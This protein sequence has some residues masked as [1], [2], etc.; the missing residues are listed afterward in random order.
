M[1]KNNC[2]LAHKKGMKNNI[3][4][5]TGIAVLG[6]GFT[7]CQGQLSEKPPVHPNP[8]MDQMM[9]MEAQEENTFFADGRSMREP[10]PGTVARGLAKLDTEYYEG[11]DAAGNFVSSNPVDLTQAFLYRGK[12]RYEVFCTPCHGQA[13]EGDGIIMVGNYGYVPAPSFH[14]PRIQQ[15]PDGEIYSAIH[16]GVRTMPSYRTQIRVEDR[17]AIVGYVRALQASFNVNEA[18]L[19]QFGGDV[20]ELQSAYRA[21]Q[22]RQDSIKEARAAQAGDKAENGGG[23]AATIERGQEVSIQNACGACHNTD[24]AAGG[25]GPTWADL[26]GSEAEVVTQD[27]Q[28]ITITKDEEYIRESILDPEAKKMVGYEQG[29]MIA[30]DFLSE[31][32]IESLVLYI[33]SLSDN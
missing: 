20:N 22:A 18:E 14:D 6:I 17:W 4:R 3:I 8:N 19:V 9:R 16:N 25:I 2:D 33:K 12:D 28:T 21:E 32:D 24:G 30:Y 7:A 11:V 15:M 5:L 1:M 10:V 23:I 29:F 13:G 31:T 26:F 27:G